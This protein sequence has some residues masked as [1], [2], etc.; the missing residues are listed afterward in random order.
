VLS[1]C[2]SG[3]RCTCSRR[4]SQ[5][6]QAPFDF[7]FIDADK[8]TTADYF[9]WAVK[10]SRR[11]DLIVVDNVVR[12]GAVLDPDSDDAN[13]QGMRRFNDVVAG[14]SRVS[15]TVVHTVGGKGHDGLPSRSSLAEETSSVRSPVMR[16]NYRDGSPRLG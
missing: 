11:G 8:P 2:A 13:M 10:L 14:E 6:G 7:V 1:R 12:H 16:L 9:T 5:K 15:A 4:S 3:A